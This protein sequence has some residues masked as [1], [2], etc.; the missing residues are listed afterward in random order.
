MTNYDLA[1]IIESK[2]AYRKK[3]AQMPIAKKLLL[4]EKMRERDLTIA[5]SRSGLA[6]KLIRCSEKEPK[7]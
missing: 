6:E 2:K 1:S 5:K 7:E 3:L 4:I